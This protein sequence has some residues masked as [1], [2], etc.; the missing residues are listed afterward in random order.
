MTVSHNFRLQKEASDY[1]KLQKALNAEELRST[2]STST[3]EQRIE[4]LDKQYQML[5]N[6]YRYN[7]LKDQ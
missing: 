3:K 4:N 7:L 6:E 2:L 5:E 1:K